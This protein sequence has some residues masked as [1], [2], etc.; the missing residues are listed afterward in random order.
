MIKKFIYLTKPGIIFGNFISVMGGFF[1][2]SQG[3][4]D[5][6]LLLVTLLGTSLVV[7]SGCVVNNI[8]DQ[9]I[10]VKMERTRNRALVKKSV[11]NTAAFIYAAVLGVFGFALL[12]FFTNLLAVAF[13]AFGFFVYV[14]LYSLYLKRHSIHQTL[15]G[16]LS[17][18]CPPVI[19]YCA[20]ANQFDVGALI[21]FILFCIWQM[22]HSFA[23][24]IFRLN[25]YVS[26]RIP[27]L[28]AK[29]GIY[30]TK[31][32]SAVYV[33]LFMLTGSLLYVF[34][35]VGL[36][37]LIIFAGLCAYW[38]YLAV[39]GFKAIDDRVWARRFFLFSV[40]LITVFS[41]VISID[42]QLQP[43]Y[44]FIFKL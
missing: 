28:P 26:A 33:L 42:Y 2:A 23:I 21:L 36:I 25:D 10:D 19:G 7:A 43:S 39:S 20:V 29:K 41:I 17:G 8:I 16:S 30:I 12:Y 9:D 44:G 6:W 31:L 3:N 37:Y 40:I 15:V 22:P 27:V 11:S 13:A 1:L 35:Y 24:A 32:Q 34:H 14:V 4:I 5:L 18:A 38:L